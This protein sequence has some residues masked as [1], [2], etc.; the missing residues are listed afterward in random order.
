MTHLKKV[1]QLQWVRAPYFAGRRVRHGFVL[2]D[3]QVEH[4]YW[5]TRGEI[6]KQPPVRSFHLK[7]GD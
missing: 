2:P 7:F 6:E 3:S 1:K 5:R 4:R